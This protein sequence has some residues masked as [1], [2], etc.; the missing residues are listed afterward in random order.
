MHQ[1]RPEQGR[2]APPSRVGR[3]PQNDQGAAAHIGRR[4]GGAI[5][6]LQRVFAERGRFAQFGL[7]EERD[8]A[9]ATEGTVA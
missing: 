9:G 1:D 4:D 8:V 3:H 5:E 6:P 7:T 2:P